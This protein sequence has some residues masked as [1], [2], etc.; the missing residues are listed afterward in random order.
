LSQWT[1][2]ATNVSS[3]S[4]NFTITVTNTVTPGAG[5]RFYILQLK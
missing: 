2:V 3:A 5:R 4:G 1:R